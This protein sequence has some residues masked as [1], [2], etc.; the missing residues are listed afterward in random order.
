[1]DERLQLLKNGDENAFEEFVL[2]HRKEA[3]NFALS[4]LKDYYA[5]EDVVQDSFAIFY[6]YRERLRDYSTL[7]SYLFSIIHNKSVDYIRDNNKNIYT[8]YNIASTISP[9]EIIVNKEKEYR[10]MD[11]FNKLD[12]SQKSI[13][14]LYAF[15]QMSYREISEVLGISLSKVKINIFRARKK[16]KALYAEK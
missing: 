4:I 15:Q 6:V 8:D 2:K 5:A 16:L 7:K 14:Y 11:N 3:V 12:E 9:E 10:F 13:L 1:M